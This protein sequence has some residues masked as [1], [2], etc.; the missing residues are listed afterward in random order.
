MFDP[1]EGPCTVFL[2]TAQ[3]TLINVQLKVPEKLP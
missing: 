2:N 1:V 3:P